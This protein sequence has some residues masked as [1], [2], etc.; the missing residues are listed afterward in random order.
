MTA[1]NI[2]LK[3]GS[4]R[5]NGGTVQSA[6]IEI[7]RQNWG[8]HPGSPLFLVLV[9]ERRWAPPEIVDQRFALVLSIT[10]EDEEV[11]LHA[12]L[13]QR[14]QLFVRQRQRV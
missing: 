1:H 9:C 7:S 6:W 4:N 11:D 5:R 14:V 10:H 3:P 2:K 13:R 12:R 8:Y